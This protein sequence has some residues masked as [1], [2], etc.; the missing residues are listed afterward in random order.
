MSSVTEKLATINAKV[1]RL[2]RDLNGTERENERLRN[3]AESLRRRE[4]ELT[5]RCRE[6]E[7]QVAVL[8]AA[9]GRLDDETR[10]ELEKR[11]GQYIREIDRC[12]ALLGH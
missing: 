9:A 4:Q 12:I 2:L 3:E 5:T 10:K 1:S 8:K 7:E 11:L 6:L